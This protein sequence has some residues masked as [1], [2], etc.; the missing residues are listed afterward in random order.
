MRLGLYPS[1]GYFT[2]AI[3]A[4]VYVLKVSGFFY[5]MPLSLTFDLYLLGSLGL[6]RSSPDGFM[7]R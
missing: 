3:A 7:P 1:P 5:H 2:G 6:Q 4:S